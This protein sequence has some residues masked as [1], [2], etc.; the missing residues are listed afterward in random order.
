MLLAA[1][2]AAQ[3]EPWLREVARIP[4]PQMRV[5]A[6]DLSPDGRLIAAATEQRE[7]VLFQLDPWSEQRRWRVDGVAPILDL[8]VDA[9]GAQVVARL[10]PA[11]T[12]KPTEIAWRL[13]GAVDDHPRPRPPRAETAPPAELATLFPEAR[14]VRADAGRHV[15]VFRA[16]GGFGVWRGGRWRWLGESAVSGDFALTADGAF[17]LLKRAG[18]VATFAVDGARR[19]SLPLGFGGDVV[20]APTA[21]GAGFVAMSADEIVVADAQ[22]ERATLRLPLRSFGVVQDEP[23]RIAI[24]P[25][26][27]HVVVSGWRDEDGSHRLDLRTH[28]AQPL[29]RARLGMF[30]PDD[31]TGVLLFDGWQCCSVRDAKWTWMPRAGAPATWPPVAMAMVNGA[32]VPGRAEIVLATWDDLRRCDVRDGR[33]LAAIPAQYVWRVGVVADHLIDVR[34]DVHEDEQLELRRLDDLGVAARM[35]CPRDS[36]GLSIDPRT[37]ARAPRIAWLDNGAIVV[38]DV[39]QSAR[40]RR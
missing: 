24:S 31:D 19:W 17:V 27:D 36:S 14:I 4:V 32:L 13:D 9:D 29:P 25:R 15:A 3:G 1:L 35:P 8:W 38:A 26:G 33:V 21:N 2:A 34:G 37:A 6:A 40:E 39:R 28:A 20:M 16:G 5:V 22:Q 10:L 7:V 12:E 11:D 30:W 18:S 23:A